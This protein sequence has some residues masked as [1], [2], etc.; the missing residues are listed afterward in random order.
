MITVKSDGFYAVLFIA[1]RC[2][3]GLGYNSIAGTL[4]HV[5]I[6]IINRICTVRVLDFGKGNL[7]YFFYLFPTIYYVTGIDANIILQYSI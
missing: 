6:F 5:T 2:L 4:S 1:G 3:R 7:F